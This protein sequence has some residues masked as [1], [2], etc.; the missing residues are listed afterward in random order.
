[1]ED[2]GSGDVERFRE[3]PNIAEKIIEQGAAMRPRVRQLIPANGRFTGQPASPAVAGG[4]NIA[5][6]S[7]LNYE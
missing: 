7:S 4:A 6:R 3:P 1:M 2:M 5:V